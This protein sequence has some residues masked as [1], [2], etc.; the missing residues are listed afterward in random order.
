MLL[1]GL[2]PE[3]SG[4]F[5]LSNLAVY[6]AVVAHLKLTCVHY[7]DMRKAVMMFVDRHVV[8]MQL[9]QA[10]HTPARCQPSVYVWFTVFTR[11]MVMTTQRIVLS[12]QEQTTCDVYRTEYRRT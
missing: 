7:F 3:T 4:A 9:A 2:A 11:L 6:D 12:T 1:I 8:R 10:R 5:S